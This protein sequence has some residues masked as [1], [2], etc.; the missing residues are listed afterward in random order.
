MDIHLF[1][2]RKTHKTQPHADI[3]RQKISD[4][5][6]KIEVDKRR[7]KTLQGKCRSLS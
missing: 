7:K 4:T 5:Y 2:K 3:S 1:K 6:A